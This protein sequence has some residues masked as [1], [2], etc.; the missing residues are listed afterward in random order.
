MT[1][2]IRTFPPPSLWQA[3]F[4][5]R[6]AQ[7]V[8]ASASTDEGVTWEPPAATALPNNNAGIAA[9]TLSSGATLLVFNNETGGAGVRTPLTVALSYDHGTTWPYSRNLQVRLRLR[10]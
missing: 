8:Y 9:V 10:A 3:Y 6:R 7:H 2:H 4:R 1:L 5:D